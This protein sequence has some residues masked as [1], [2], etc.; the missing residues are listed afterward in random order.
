MDTDGVLALNPYI[1][2]YSY[3]STYFD[4]HFPMGMVGVSL[5]LSPTKVHLLDVNLT[6]GE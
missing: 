3:V 1:D 2:L 6:L 5:Y 4:F